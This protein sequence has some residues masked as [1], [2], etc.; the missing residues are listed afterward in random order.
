MTAAKKHMLAVV[1]QRAAFPVDKRVCPAAE[2]IP[3]LQEHRLYS[4]VG[5][6]TGARDSGEPT[7]YNRDF[8]VNG[9]P[10][11]SLELSSAFAAI[12]SFRAFDKE[13]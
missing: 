13:T 3:G 4:R 12:E 1:D 10:P 5:Q 2:V 8:G 11:L 6:I 7:A 9:R